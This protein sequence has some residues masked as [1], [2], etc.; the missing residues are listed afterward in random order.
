MDILEGQFTTVANMGAVNVS[1]SY[2]F[3]QLTALLAERSVAYDWDYDGTYRVWGVV[4]QP[5][6]PV[7]EKEQARLRQAAQ[8][9]ELENEAIQRHAQQQL[10]DA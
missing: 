4:P 7:D 3:T 5:P 6:V 8:V 9:K 10:E 1:T 2:E